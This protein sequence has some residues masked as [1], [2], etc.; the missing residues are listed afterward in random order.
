MNFCIKLSLVGI[1]SI[2]TACSSIYGDDGLIK[3]SSYEYLEAKQVEP[4]V[5]PEG[6]HQKRKLNYTL[7]PQIGEIAAKA[8]AGKEL[9]LQAPTQI[10]DVLDNIRVNKQS[11]LP[12]VFIIDEKA[13]VAQSIV[14]LFTENKVELT[15][16]ESQKVIETGWVALD[17][18]GVWLGLAGEEDVDEF[19]AKY[20]VV[21]GE[22]VQRGELSL[23]V[24]RIA[25]QKL[26]PDTAQWETIPSF[27]E[28]GAQMLNMLIANYD[29]AATARE[30][31]ARA[32][33]P[34]G[35]KVRLAK[36]DKGNAA[37][38][39]EVAIEQVW[40]LLPEILPTLNFNINDKDR[41]LM[42]YFVSYK[43]TESGF[44]ASLFT[45]EKVSLPLEAGEYQIAVRQLGEMTAV[46]FSDAQGSPLDIKKLT[47]MFPQ[48]SASFGRQR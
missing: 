10:L 32:K 12:S 24:E 9:A 35:I 43:P 7:V 40:A 30:A 39:T 37:L 23:H 13:F 47:E 19:R 44:F 20:R 5:L 16:K 1:C 29:N 42:T 11:D 2:L 26:N 4:L 17:S 14:N 41:R 28:D 27:W 3:D 31:E 6:L 34:K 48:L 25:A 45:A 21:F 46:I 38:V 33:A 36:D 22:G 8:P 18:R 15:K